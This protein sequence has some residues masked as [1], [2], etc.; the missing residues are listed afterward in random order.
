MTIIRHHARLAALASLIA[1]TSGAGY[2]AP[3]KAADTGAA[4][5]GKLVFERQCAACHGQGPGDDGSPRLPGTDALQRKYGG[6]MPGALEKRTDL[7]AE[8]IRTFVRHGSGPMPMFRK[9]ELSDAAIDDIAA[10][11]KVSSKP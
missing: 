9:A 1:L 10:Y 3:K 2:A 7:N 4:V 6:A 5:R 11:L 8:I